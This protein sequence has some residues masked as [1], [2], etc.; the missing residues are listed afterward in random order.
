MPV[1]IQSGYKFKFNHKKL[2]NNYSMP[3]AEAY[4]SIYGIGYMLSGKR[5]IVSPGKTT[6]AI[7]GMVQF[8]SKD[9]YHKTSPIS[10]EIYEC[11]SLKFRN[12][13]AEDI[14]K[15]IGKDNFDSLFSQISISLTEAAQQKIAHIMSMIEYEWNNYDNFSESV[16]EGLVI[17]LFVTTLRGQVPTAQPKQCL[18]SKHIALID[19]LN[20]IEKH[21]PEDPS[22][23]ETSAATHISS[24]YLSRL[25]ASELGTSYS[26]SLEAI[27][28]TSAMNLLIN[29]KLPIT[30]VAAQ[31]GYHNSNYFCDAFKRAIGVSPLKYRKNKC[32]ENGYNS[33][34]S[35]VTANQI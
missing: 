19:A 27:K 28:L 13:F 30:E 9:L 12:S 14:I 17:Q 24:A 31:S 4:N 26:K 20:Y 10:E 23:D 1:P 16:I 25:F 34:T 5:I 35:P 3:A 33:P 18:S 8:I 6:I 22:L 15:I 11:Y 7:P 29:T 2:Y 32:G 21:Y